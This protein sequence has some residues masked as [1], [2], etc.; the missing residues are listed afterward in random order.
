MVATLRGSPSRPQPAPRVPAPGT[1]HGDEG[2]LGRMSLST[3]TG[4]HGEPSGQQNPEPTRRPRG[5]PAQA[6]PPEPTSGGWPRPPCHVPPEILVHGIRS[7]IQSCHL[8]P[9]CRGA[10]R[11]PEPG[12]RE[13]GPPSVPA[14]AGTSTRSRTQSQDNTEQSTHEP[15][16]PA[17][18]A[19][20]ASP[21]QDSHRRGQRRYR[22]VSTRGPRR[23]TTA[24]DVA[25]ALPPTH[26]A[27]RWLRRVASTPHG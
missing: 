11:N 16:V 14:A 25:D 2:G 1:S 8:R 26:L 17:G 18:P 4:E 3:A 7:T 22:R 15:R 13:A 21:C 24:L 27:S 9:L 12:P 20:A 23:A 19:A 6:A 5:G 10:G